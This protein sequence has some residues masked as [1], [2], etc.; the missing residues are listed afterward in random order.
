MSST[1]VIP[2]LNPFDPSI[3]KFVWDPAPLV[4]DTSP[5]VLYADENG[6]VRYNTSALNIMNIDEKQIECVYRILRRN[7]DDMSV[8]FE[9]PM[10]IKPPQKVSS[11]F[12]HLTCKDLRGKV[13][14]DKL[15]TH[16]EK[17][18]TKRSVQVQEESADQL[19]VFMFGIDSVSRS[20]SIRKLPRTIRF[21]TEELRAYDFKGYMKV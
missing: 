9:P 21:L 14:F 11:D 12:F 6:V 1:C 15:I 16:V 17:E 2:N 5:V 10:P 19:S 18:V 3:M 13:L 4:C 8:F 7:T 20:T